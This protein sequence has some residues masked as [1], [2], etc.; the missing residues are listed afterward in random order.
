M[1]TIPTKKEEIKVPSSSQS[2]TLAIK[3]SSLAPYVLMY[4]FWWIAFLGSLASVV[5]PELAGHKPNSNAVVSFAFWIGI[6]ATISAY[7]KGKSL[8]VW[9]LV[10]FLG[11][12]FG[13]I[14]VLS[15]IMPFIK[16]FV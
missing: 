8:W 2:I 3:I 15:I 7:H 10:G 5:I 1:A 6:A 12:G 14:F 11:I 9:F 13:A 16:A 4:L